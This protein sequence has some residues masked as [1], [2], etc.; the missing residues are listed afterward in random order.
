MIKKL[1]RRL[2]GKADGDSAPPRMGQ[3]EVADLDDLALGVEV[4]ERAAADDLPA[5]SVDRGERQ[6]P[7]C[8][9]EPGQIRE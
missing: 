8:L 9:G 2:L 6:Q 5:A 3:H 1:I 4:V 7:S